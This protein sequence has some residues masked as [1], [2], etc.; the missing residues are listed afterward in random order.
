MFPVESNAIFL[1]AWDTLI[2]ALRELGWCFYTLIGGG[3]RF[4]FAWDARPE[5]ID[6]LAGDIRRVVAAESA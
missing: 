6:E 2:A 4:M 3:A 5:R 1:R